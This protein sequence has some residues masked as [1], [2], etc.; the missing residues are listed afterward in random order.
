M[1]QQLDDSGTV[2]LVM[3]A[4]NAVTRIGGGGHSWD[5]TFGRSGYVGGAVRALPDNGSNVGEPSNL[6]GNSPRLDFTA[7]FAKTGNH[8]VWVRGEAI[9]KANTLWVAVDNGTPQQI[10]IPKLQGWV[11]DVSSNLFNISNTGIH[12]I[13]VWM[14]EDG[15]R[16]DRIVFTKSTSYTPTGEGPPESVQQ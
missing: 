12:T 3:E 11:W 6:D 10:A 13:K 5:D 1:Y 4:E 14:R 8:S 7:N 2:L 15:F 9:S 16:L